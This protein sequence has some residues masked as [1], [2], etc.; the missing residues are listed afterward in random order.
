M[1]VAT[2]P[3]DLDKISDSGSLLMN[4]KL[5]GLGVAFFCF[6]TDAGVGFGGLLAMPCPSHTWFPCFQAY[7]CA[8]PSFTVFESILLVSMIPQSVTQALK[9]CKAIGKS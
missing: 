6:S 4:K 1:E 9:G 7:V 5:L 8:V 2:C 3:E